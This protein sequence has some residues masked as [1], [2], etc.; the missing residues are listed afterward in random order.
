MSTIKL[1]IK[2]SEKEWVEINHNS[3]LL[4]N[5]ITLDDRKQLQEVVFDNLSDKDGAPLIDDLT[6]AKFTIDEKKT[7][8][9][10]RINFNI[11]RQFCCS[12]TSSCQ[13]DYIDF[14]FTYRPNF[15]SA[16][17]DFVNWNIEN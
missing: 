12:D 10:F 5:N 16:L 11:N 2:V 8:G 15:I 1:N 9:K 3:T 4:I 14:T 17:G 13:S 7:N 6:V